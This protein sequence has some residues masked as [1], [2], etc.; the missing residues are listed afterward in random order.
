LKV[1]F[2][3]TSLKIFFKTSCNL[4]ENFP[5]TSQKLPR[6]FPETSQKLPR[7]FPETSQKS[8]TKSIRNLNKTHT[9]FIYFKKV[10]KKPR[11]FHE[12]LI[13]LCKK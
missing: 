6:N 7:N 5:E 1:Y 12:S 4:P 11:L 2:P 3:E 9:N 13:I 10:R 8:A